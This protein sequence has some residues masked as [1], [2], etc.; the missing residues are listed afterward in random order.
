VKVASGHH[1]DDVCVCVCVYIYNV[2][3]IYTY[4]WAPSTTADKWPLR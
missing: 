2:L 1:D 4:I 3:Y